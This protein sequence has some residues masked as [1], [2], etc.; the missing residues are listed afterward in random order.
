MTEIKKAAVFGAGVMGAGIAAQVANAGV[1]VVL[2]DIAAEDGGNRSAIAEGAVEKL[3]KT[4]PAPLMHKRNARLI[5][6]GNID[7]DMGLIAD[8]DWIIE[9]I[10]ERVDLKQG[11]YKKIQAARKPGSIVSSNTSTIPLARL[12]EGMA[13]DFQSDF[14][15]THFF[16]PPRYLRL[17]E[18]VT[19]ERTRAHAVETITRFADFRL[20]KTIVPCKDTPGFIANRI[21]IYWLQCGVVRAMDEGLSIEEADA[22]MGRPAGIPKTGVFGLLDMVGL[23]LMPHVLGGMAEA[24]PEQDP[25]HEV[26]REP[27]LIKRMIADGYTGRKGKGGFYRLKP[28]AE[29][30]IKEAIDLGTGEYRTAQKPK[31]KSLA[32]AKKGG[33]KAMLEHGDKTANYAWWVLARTLSYAARLVPEISDD[34]VGVDDAMRLG[35]NWKFGPFELIDQLGTDWFAERLRDDGLPVPKLLEMAN[36]RP[37]YRTEGGQLQFLGLDGDY[38]DVVRPEGVLLLADIKRRRKPVMK[39]R[40]A[41]LWDIGDGVLCL[42]FHSKMNIIDHPIIELMSEAL[43]E[44]ERNFEGLVIGNH[45]DNFSVGANLVLMLER[46]RRKNWEALDEKICAFQNANMR[47]RFSPKPV[48][49]A[50]AGM[51]FGG[52]C[53]IVLGADGVCAAAETYI[54]L[55]ELRVGLIPGAGGTKEMAVRSSAHDYSGQATAL[56]FPYLK[57]AFETIAYSKVSESGE[58]AKELGYLRDTDRVSIN[59]AHHLHNAKQMVLSMLSN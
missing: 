6:T 45:A 28:D 9:A 36:G 41:S 14:L 59:R 1:P 43:D 12:T 24:L 56:A 34:I 48:V 23:D 33:L 18:L 55:V 25:F 39:N 5:T 58:H 27:E 19:G 2:L 4:D 13:E 49:A 38:R 10:I 26:F 31:L 47:L 50:P 44:V 3:L 17:L 11:L 51:A 29:E 8:C 20:G 54:G 42:E 35:Y 16:N 22:V 37:F 53:E 30:K 21:G 15:I 57:R 7:D 52:G 46:A 40:S 32:K